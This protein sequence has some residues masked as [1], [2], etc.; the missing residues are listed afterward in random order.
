MPRANSL[1]GNCGRWREL[2]HFIGC[3]VPAQITMTEMLQRAETASLT[4]V[5]IPIGAALFMIALIGSAAVVP[6][7]R[8][9]HF[10]QALIYVGVIML[11]RRDSAWGFGAGVAIA[12][13]WNGLQLFVTHNFQAGARLFWSF[14]DTGEIHRFETMMVPIGSIGHF[15]LIFACMAAVLSQSSAN[16]KWWKFFAGGV[17]CLVYLGLIVFLLL[18]RR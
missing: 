18:P 3:R 4:R 2:T 14:L 9:L 10:F 7:L 5:W 15:I 11:A 6:Q 12:L 16:K 13:F 1:Q 8:A 17:V